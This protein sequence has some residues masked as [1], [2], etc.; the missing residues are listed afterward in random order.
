MKPEVMEEVKKCLTI[1]CGSIAEPDKYYEGLCRACR[2][3]I[4]C[5]REQKEHPPKIKWWQ[6]IYKTGW[7]E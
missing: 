5:Q 4:Q 7:G 1:N 2:I 6:R 3:E